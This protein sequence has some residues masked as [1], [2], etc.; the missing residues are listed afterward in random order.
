MRIR[1][2]L[3]D[4]GSPVPSDRA[5]DSSSMDMDSSADM[6]L[7]TGL[8]ESAASDMSGMDFTEALPSTAG[9]ATD[10]TDGSDTS[11]M[12]FTEALPSTAGNAMDRTEGS[13][14]SGMDLTE[15]WRAR[16]VS[17]ASA[18]DMDLTT[19][20]ITTADE[21]DG[22]ISMELTTALAPRSDDSPDTSL[23]SAAEQSVMEMTAMWGHIAEEA[24]RQRE[25]AG[26]SPRRSPVRRQTMFLS[27]ERRPVVPERVSEPP[28]PP[29]P[30]TPVERARSVS[31][32]RRPPTPGA[33]LAAL[34]RTAPRMPSEGTSAS[35]F[36]P[37][38]PPTTPTRFRQSLRGGVPSPGYQHSPPQ[39][40]PMTPKGS[41]TVA[42]ASSVPA[43]LAHPTTLSPSPAAARGRSGSVRLSEVP[44]A[45]WPRSPFLHSLIRQRGQRVSYTASPRSDGDLSD[46]DASFH[47]PLSEFLQRVGLKFHEDM[48]ASRTRTDRP[49]DTGT[50]PATCVQHAKMA[51][52]AA[53]MLQALRSACHEL[54]QHVEVGRERLQ[55][56]EQD[57]YARPPA[58]VQEWGQLD[59]EDMRRSM[60]GQLNVHKQA[61]RAA[62]MHDYYGWRT[63]MQY[64]DDMAR[65][66]AQ[67][68]D[69]LRAEAARVQERHN[70]LEQELLPLLRT[71]HAA[72][73]RRV[74]EA[75]ARQR[76][77]RACDADEL[78]QLHASMEEQDQ[79]LQGMRTKHR[80]AR[81][82]LARVRA[83]IEEAAVRRAQT[84]EGIRAAR[85]VTDQIRGCTPGE[86]VRLARRIQ[87]METLLQ[88]SLTSK[89]PTLLQLTYAHRLQV[90]VEWDERRGTVRR[91]AVSPVHTMAM[92]P[93]DMAALAVIRAHMDAQA[94]AQVTAVLRTVTALWRAHL[95]VRAEI[96]QLRSWMPVSMAPVDDAETRMELVATLLLEACAAKAEVH[97]DLDLANE[98]P[99]AAGRVRVQAVYGTIPYVPPAHSRTTT[100]AR[101]IEEG[102]AR[103]GEAPGALVRAVQAAEAALGRT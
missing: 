51:A 57:F 94:P 59:D 7:S 80:D 77:I 54:K 1:T 24:T 27:P 60:K 74:D 87:H 84:E 47:L 100:L 96:E 88:W 45:M 19:Q 17:N 39:R 25:A 63:D 62:A 6:D 41:T 78:R 67:H 79:V 58:F 73:R 2:A 40:A 23:D 83:R 32:R 49:I 42:T 5:W 53:P 101:A 16:R 50:T 86:A 10:R 26:R 81:E 20:S 61:A 18:S 97:I 22:S 102:L 8:D 71:H 55:T 46:A 30:A 43:R 92:A 72:L 28:E 4:R 103:S 31:P 90:A 99:V 29:A 3:M 52:G 69:V 85:A 37:S 91:V 36:S 15:A 70:T 68:R 9:N 98:A 56:M 38:K 64:D 66:L 93:L 21:S 11:G 34:P 65:M 95:A 82:Q 48:T 75:H 14:T 44:S 76:E 89:T 35:P 12:D 13:D 33:G